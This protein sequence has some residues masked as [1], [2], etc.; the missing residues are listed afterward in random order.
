MAIVR[1]PL[2]LLWTDEMA[3]KGDKTSS[4]QELFDRQAWHSRSSEEGAFSRV[5]AQ[6]HF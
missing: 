5:L 4:R 2:L 6:P 1:M 3:L